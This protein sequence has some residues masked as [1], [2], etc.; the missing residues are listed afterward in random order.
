MRTEAAISERRTLVARTALLA[1]FCFVAVATGCDPKARKARKELRHT[2]PTVRAKAAIRLARMEGAD[3][4]KDIGPL[5]NDRSAPVRLAAVKALRLIESKETLPFL[6]TAVRDADPEVRLSAV[7][8]LA[9]LGDRKAVG[10][11]LSRLGDSSSVVR[12]AAR[13]ALEDLGITRREQ[14][15]RLARKALRRWIARL[16]ENRE[17]PTRREAIF[18]LSL[19]G[20][21]SVTKRILELMRSNDPEILEAAAKGLGRIGGDK[22]TRALL[23]A[24]SSPIR[25]VRES[26]AQGLATMVKWHQPGQWVGEL[27]EA[28]H[29]AVRRAA[30]VRLAD[31][32]GDEASDIDLPVQ[33]LC[34]LLDDEVAATAKAA[35]KLLRHREAGCKQTAEPRAAEK[36][37]ADRQH[38][39]LRE[40]Q[41]EVLLG[42][43]PTAEQL[44]DLARWCEANLPPSHAFDLLAKLEAP[45]V[46]DALRKRIERVVSD[47]ER[48]TEK[49][50]TE[51]EW[52]TLTGHSHAKPLGARPHPPTDEKSRAVTRLL[53]RFPERGSRRLELLPP[54]VSADELRRALSLLGHLPGSERPLAE[55]AADGSRT[56][57]EAALLGLAETRYEGVPSPTAVRAVKKAIAG[58]AGM[59]SA[60]AR[61][62]GAMGKYG[63]PVLAQLLVKE[64]SSK[65]RARV[66][67][68]MARTG[69]TAARAPLRKAAEKRLELAVVRALHELEDP[70]A[71]PIL[72]RQLKKNPPDVLLQERLALVE[73]LG[74]LGEKGKD[75]VSALIDELDHPHWTLREAAARSLG[76]LGDRRAVEALEA[77]VADFYRPVREACRRALSVIK[78]S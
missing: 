56:S 74:D 59:R 34:S 5:V 29:P 36:S 26:A 24:L 78:G 27:L 77:R 57:R 41:I 25:E 23:S 18:H 11:L 39:V 8:G 55:L 17:T 21:S 62:L 48:E 71:A 3:A 40:V 33:L 1:L 46:R 31:Q 63:L 2:T 30:A 60:A 32:I 50:L 15:S 52:K 4:V 72:L 58:P 9:D 44:A 69:L 65:V 66:A 22:S 28:S 53:S 76:K 54:R 13:F 6:L 42:R 16:A 47:Y 51:E 68:S 35:A 73:A 20:K 45:G 7:R 10:T 38:G 12:R 75:V 14:V 37:R 70:K 61:A 67:R 64:K 19:H 43:S 49:W